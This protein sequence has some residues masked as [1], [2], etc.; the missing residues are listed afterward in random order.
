[1]PEVETYGPRVP[2]QDGVRTSYEN[3]DV[4]GARTRGDV[5]R[6]DIDASSWLE[7]K[8]EPAAPSSHDLVVKH[9]R[10]ELEAI[11]P[12]GKLAERIDD[13]RSGARTA[14]LQLLSA[15]RWSADIGPFYNGDAV[16]HLLGRT[17]RALS[18]QAVNK[19]RDLLA[20]RTGSG[21]VVYPAFQFEGRSPVQGLREVLAVFDDVPVSRWTL[22]SWLCN[23]SRGLDGRS[24]MAELRSGNLD[25]V[26]AA[27]GRWAAGLRT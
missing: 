1:M 17:G 11:D 22:A 18:R 2:A 8:H 27:A 9:F 7:P 13:P 6:Q 4:N 20:L 5:Q 23:P 19:R 21:R 14:A 16:R 25:T 26:V 3:R 15:A 10:R 24:P 12:D